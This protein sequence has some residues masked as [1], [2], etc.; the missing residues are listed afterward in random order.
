MRVDT[1]KK[2]ILYCST[3]RLC[4]P[5]KKVT[6]LNAT[7]FPFRNTL[8]NKSYLIYNYTISMYSLPHTV[9]KVSGGGGEG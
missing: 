8:H 6:F 4:S 5:S 9:L 3:W 2:E 1:E 7:E